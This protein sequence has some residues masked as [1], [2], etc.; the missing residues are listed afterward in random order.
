MKNGSKVFRKYFIIKCFTLDE[1]ELKKIKYSHNEL[2]KK[3]KHSVI[4]PSLE[5]KKEELRKRREY[6]QPISRSELDHHQKEYEERLKVKLREYKDKREKWYKDIGYND[7]DPCKLFN[8]LIYNIDNIAIYQT[9]ILLKV[10][11]ESKQPT[12][13]EKEVIKAKSDKQVNYAKFVREMHKPKVS[14]RKKDEMEKL[15]RLVEQSGMSRGLEK[16]SIAKNDRHDKRNRSVDN[17]INRN[18]N[19]SAK[20]RPYGASLSANR[21]PRRKY[22]ENTM[23]PK[24]KLRR[25]PVVEDYLLKK[26]IKRQQQE[27]EGYGNYGKRINWDKVMST[28]INYYFFNISLNI[29]DKEQTHGRFEQE[30]KS[31]TD[32]IEKQRLELISK[33]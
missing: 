25:R 6:F 3:Y 23:I 15:I 16:N 20:L 27:S 29:A 12:I 24:P 30:M 18:G 28:F 32:I 4:I 31:S 8:M 21:I 13:D 19:K 14:N 7:Y 9:N 11:N 5:R 17:A 10:E 26:R 1:K 2:K 22:V 33:S